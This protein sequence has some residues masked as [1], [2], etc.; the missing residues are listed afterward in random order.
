M[1]RI[2]LNKYDRILIDKQSYIIIGL[3]YHIRSII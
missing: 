3:G 1:Q 2:V